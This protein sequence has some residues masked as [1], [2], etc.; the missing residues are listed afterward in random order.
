MLAFIKVRLHFLHTTWKVKI[1][2]DK[3]LLLYVKSRLFALYTYRVCVTFV[4]YNILLVGYENIM[5]V[6]WCGVIFSDVTVA[7]I[8]LRQYN[9]A[10]I[11]SFSSTKSEI[12]SY[13]N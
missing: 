11:T 4:L 3:I 12:N 9:L 8:H 1:N 7:I 13:I 10:L 2:N 5:Y 6:F